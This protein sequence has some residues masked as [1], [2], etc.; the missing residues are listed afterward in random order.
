MP[1]A[2]IKHCEE[3][4]IA[5]R[6]NLV[7]GSPAVRGR[8]TSSLIHCTTWLKSA[9]RSSSLSS[10]PANETKAISF[11]GLHPTPRLSPTFTLG[12]GGTW[13]GLGVLLGNGVATIAGRHPSWPQHLRR[14]PADSCLCGWVYELAGRHDASPFYGGPPLRMT[15]GFR[16]VLL[17]PM[18]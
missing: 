10:N 16:G 18:S 3:D 11:L 9:F 4:A 17:E 1:E 15:R 5:C 8:N 7:A 14:G 6:S 13:V 12:S 2:R